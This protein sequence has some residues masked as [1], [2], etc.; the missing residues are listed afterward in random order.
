MLPRF[1][2]YRCESC[3]KQGVKL[4]RCRI[5]LAAPLVLKCVDCVC[6]IAMIDAGSVGP[7]G[8][9]PD[10]R[11]AQ[12]WTERFPGWDPAVPNRVTQGGQILTYWEYALAP[13]PAM[14]WWRELLL[15]L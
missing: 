9:R 5:K 1:T 10:P 6:G 13:E 2:D 15:R 14:E 11:S 3:G 4:W 12:G 8:S 7:N